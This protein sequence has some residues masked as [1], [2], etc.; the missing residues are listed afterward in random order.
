VLMEVSGASGG[1]AAAADASQPIVVVLDRAS[2]ETVKMKSGQYSLLNCDDH[3][4]SGSSAG[5]IQ[6]LQK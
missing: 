3:Q 5:S 4:V 2:L 1:E 6:V